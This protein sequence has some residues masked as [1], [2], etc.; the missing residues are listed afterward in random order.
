MSYDNLLSED[1]GG[2]RWITINRPEKLNALNSATLAEL[3]HAV[4]AAA[5]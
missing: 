2:V 3:D 5:E 4:A 1:T